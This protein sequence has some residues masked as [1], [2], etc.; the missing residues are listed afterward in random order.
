[1]KLHD[2]KCHAC[3]F[4]NEQMSDKDL[5]PCTS[6]NCLGWMQRQLGGRPALSINQGGYSEEKKFVHSGPSVDLG[7]CEHGVKFR[8]DFGFLE[9]VQ[10]PK[11]RA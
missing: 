7:E 2:Y 1:M 9:T 6:A 8:A 10:V 5:L 4:V 11:A 3:D